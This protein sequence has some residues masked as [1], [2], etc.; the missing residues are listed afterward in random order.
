MWQQGGWASLEQTLL[1]DHERVALGYVA[2]QLSLLPGCCMF[3]C[4]QA[5]SHTHRVARMDTLTQMY[6]PDTTSEGVV[7]GGSCEDFF[8]SVSK[9][10]HWF[11]LPHSFQI[12]LRITV[13]GRLGSSAV[14][15]LP[16][17]QGVGVP[18][19]SPTSGSLPP[20]MEAPSPP[21]A[22]VSASLFV[23]LMNK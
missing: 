10:R 16:L 12:P 19:S 17:A 6:T 22:C 2:L 3:G 21:S 18:G 23:S 8:V 5:D 20:C 15:L 14:E 4:S 13:T 7:E 1:H 11:P 9:Q